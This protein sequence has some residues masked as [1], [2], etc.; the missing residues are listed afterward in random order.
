[1]QPAETPVPAGTLV[2]V[3]PYCRRSIRGISNLNRQAYFGLCDKGGTDF[4]K[5]CRSKARYDWLIKENGITFGRALGVVHGLGRW[6]EA[7]REDP[8]RP[9]FADAAYLEAKLAPH[10]REPSEEDHQLIAWLATQE[11][12][13]LLV[14]TKVDKLSRDKGNRAVARIEKEF[15]A[16]ALAFSSVSGVGKSELIGSINELVNEHLQ[17]KKA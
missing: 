9:G 11:I 13:T 2:R 7:I 4:D 14:V 6:Y 5:R 17:D 1:M 10:R 16:P 3:D 12:P 15:G 8:A